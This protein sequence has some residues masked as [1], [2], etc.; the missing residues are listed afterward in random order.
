M[1]DRIEAHEDRQLG[2]GALDDGAQQEADDNRGHTR[3]RGEH[4]EAGGVDAEAVV[5]AQRAR[6]HH[7]DGQHRRGQ[8]PRVA[9]ARKPTPSTR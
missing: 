4:G 7:K 6:C 2:P 1:T 3:S 5:L 9:C 8:G